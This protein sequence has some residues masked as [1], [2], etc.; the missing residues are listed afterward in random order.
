MFLS[1]YVKENCI[2][3]LISSF[4]LLLIFF[5]KLVYLIIEFGMI[6]WLASC[7]IYIYIYIYDLEKKLID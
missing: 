5:F 7:E 6:H 2:G 4:T 3:M 1:L